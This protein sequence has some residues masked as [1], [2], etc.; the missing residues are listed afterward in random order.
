MTSESR[1][2][3]SEPLSFFPNPC[4]FSSEIYQSRRHSF[5]SSSTT[6]ESRDVKVDNKTISL[7]VSSCSKSWVTEN[8]DV[9]SRQVAIRCGIYFSPVIEMKIRRERSLQPS[10]NMNLICFA[11]KENK[12]ILKRTPLRL[13]ETEKGRQSF[14]DIRVTVKG[15][16]LSS[17]EEKILVMEENFTRE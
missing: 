4:F 1:L 11:S 17:L 9:K 13:T 5:I 10:N 14:C 6:S 2:S 3:S 7:L 12:K 8:K 16:S 15:I